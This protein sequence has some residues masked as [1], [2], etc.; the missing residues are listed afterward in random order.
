MYRVHKY[1]ALDRAEIGYFISQVGLAA[2][3]FGVAQSDIA[4][5]ASALVMYFNYKCSPPANIVYG[6]QLDSICVD[7]TCPLVPNPKCYLYDNNYG[8]SLEPKT[9]PHCM[10]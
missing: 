3:S 10:S 4:A 9:A 8:S 7:V 6:P 1:M 2:A 5:V